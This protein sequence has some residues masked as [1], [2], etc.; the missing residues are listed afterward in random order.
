MSM[1]SMCVPFPS[2]HSFSFRALDKKENSA[3]LDFISEKGY[4]FFADL[5]IFPLSHSQHDFSHS[6]GF[7]KCLRSIFYPESIS[8]G[9]VSYGRLK[10]FIFPFETTNTLSHEL[11]GK[12][13]FSL[14]HFRLFKILMTLC[15]SW[16]ATQSE[17]RR[18]KALEKLRESPRGQQKRRRRNAEQQREEGKQPNKVLDNFHDII[19]GVFVALSF[20]DVHQSHW[21]LSEDKKKHENLL[22]ILVGSSAHFHPWLDV[23]TKFAY[24]VLDK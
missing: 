2:T 20:Q 8:F 17:M 22:V 6:F 19:W 23:Y 13:N 18:E 14:W 4:V 11:N 21:S 24:R 1:L 15:W 3:S 10:L 9:W 12:F 7:G 16:P 5:A